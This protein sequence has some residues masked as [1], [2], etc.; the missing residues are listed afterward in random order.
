MSTVVRHDANAETGFTLPEF[1]AF[2]PYSWHQPKRPFGHPNVR[3][4]D[5]MDMISFVD[6]H[7][8]YVKI[9]WR[10]EWPILSCAGDYDPPAGYEY[11]W[12]GN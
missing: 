11:Q 5:A 8:A 12:S 3:F 4:N 2:M 6:G 10:T 7:S 9:Y 1:P